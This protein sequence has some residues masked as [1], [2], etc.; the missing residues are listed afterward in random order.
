[1]QGTGSAE[2]FLANV[3]SVQIFPSL[4]DDSVAECILKFIEISLHKLAQRL[5]LG[6][7][8]V[9]VPTQWNRYFDIRL[10]I[11]H[12]GCVSY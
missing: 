11:W 4:A 7:V 9:R 1:M 3:K 10:K 2:T 6:I 8:G 5:F 12:R